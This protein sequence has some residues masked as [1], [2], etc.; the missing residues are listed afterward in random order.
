MEKSVPREVEGSKE[1]QAGWPGV[2]TPAKG[3]EKVVGDRAQL[4]PE[5]LF[6]QERSVYKTASQPTLAPCSGH[7]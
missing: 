7:H 2:G 4:L 6:S 1:S 5:P 3:S